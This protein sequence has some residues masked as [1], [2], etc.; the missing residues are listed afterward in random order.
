MRLRKKVSVGLNNWI[1]VDGVFCLLCKSIVKYT[2]NCPKIVK[3]TNVKK[4]CKNTDK[5]Q[6][7]SFSGHLKGNSFLKNSIGNT[8]NNKRFRLSCS[9][10]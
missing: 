2:I 9:A 4:N 3:P 5:I 8:G 6:N 7:M 1:K 10:C